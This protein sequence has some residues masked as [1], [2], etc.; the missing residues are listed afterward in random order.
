L[1]DTYDPTHIYAGVPDTSVVF[2]AY[3]QLAVD[4]NLLFWYDFSEQYFDNQSKVF[5][6]RLVQNNNQL[7][8]LRSTNFITFEKLLFLGL[9]HTQSTTDPSNLTSDESQESI[10]D[11]ISCTNALN[12]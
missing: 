7:P 11:G 3:S 12:T 1:W 9:D 5:Y 8:T 6:P 4:Q 2:G 10:F